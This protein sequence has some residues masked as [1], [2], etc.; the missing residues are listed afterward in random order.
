MKSINL[1]EILKQK[2]LEINGALGDC[3]T[4]SP[5]QRKVALLAMQEACN[6][7]VEICSENAE[8]LSSETPG[9][10]KVNRMSILNT[11][12]QIDCAIS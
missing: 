10:V 4:F 12:N 1:N 9:N 7:V 6:K 2:S 11:K 3:T 8:I 5:Y